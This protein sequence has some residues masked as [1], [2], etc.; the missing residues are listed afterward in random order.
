MTHIRLTSDMQEMTNQISALNA[1]FMAYMEKHTKTYADQSQADKDTWLDYSLNESAPNIIRAALMEQII[2]L[3][4]DMKVYLPEQLLQVIMVTGK[5]Q[6]LDMQTARNM[7][8]L[9]TVKKDPRGGYKVFRH[10]AYIGQVLRSDDG[11]I[12]DFIPFSRGFDVPAYTDA[13]RADLLA[14]AK[15]R[16]AEGDV[17]PAEEPIQ[18]PGDAQPAPGGDQ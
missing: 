5:N 3:K 16:I 13:E 12:A 15:T 2:K 9:I 18:T 1:V 10:G 8:A 17:E 11:E 7:A 6:R 4:A 14:L